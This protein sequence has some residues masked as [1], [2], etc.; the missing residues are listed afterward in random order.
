MDLHSP[1]DKIL[2]KNCIAVKLKQLELEEASDDE[3][4]Y[5]ENLYQIL[6]T[7]DTEALLLTLTDT[8]FKET[9]RTFNQHILRTNDLFRRKI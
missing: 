5:Y 2:L 9:Y 7:D 1:K 4:S 6:R 3:M 8:D